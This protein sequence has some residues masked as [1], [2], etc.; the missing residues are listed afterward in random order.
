MML[1]A[2]LE[3]SDYAVIVEPVERPKPVGQVRRD[4]HT[5]RVTDPSSLPPLRH[6]SALL[7]RTSKLT[8]RGGRRHIDLYQPIT[9]PRSGAAVRSA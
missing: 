4:R 3:F 5:G 9:P 2:V 6:P 7:R 1:F 8:C